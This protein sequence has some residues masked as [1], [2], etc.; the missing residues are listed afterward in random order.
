MKLALVGDIHGCWDADDAAY[1]NASDYDA[2]LLVGDLP[3]R[4]HGRIW[5][6]ARQVARLQKPAYI[7]AGNHD[8]VSL[9]HL[10]SEALGVPSPIAGRVQHLRV[11]R[12]RR[13]LRPVQLLAYERV[14]LV[15]A[16]ARLHLIACRPHSMGGAFAFATHLAR[17]YGVRTMDESAAR[18]CALVDDAAAADPSVPVLFFAHNGPSGLGGAP[19]DIWGCDFKRGAGDWGDHDLRRAIDHARER[20][21]RVLAVVAG[22]MHHRTKTREQRVWHLVEDGVHYVNAARVPRW[23]RRDGVPVRHHVALRFDGVDLDVAERLVDA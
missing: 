16:G 14:P 20:G 13:L 17:A 9:P 1:F 15:A 10:I 18:L 6:I 22:H 3:P 4:N 21:L 11:G 12:L 23:T 7:I 2:V 19:A 5:E 8:G